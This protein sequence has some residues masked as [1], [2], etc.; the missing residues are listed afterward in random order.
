MKELPT[1]DEFFSPQDKPVD[2]PTADEFFA[3]PKPSTL[4][5]GTKAA[6]SIITGNGIENPAVNAFMDNTSAGRIMGAFGHAFAAGGEGG[7]LGIELGSDT[8]KLLTK[9]GV[10][11]DHEKNENEFTKSVNEAFIRPAAVVIDTEWRGFNAILGGIGSALQQSSEEIDK[12]LPEPVQGLLPE[13]TEYFLMHKAEMPHIPPEITRARSVGAIGES[14]ATYFGLKE[15][16]PEQVQGRAEANL[17]LSES[18]EV[19][20]IDLNKP[21]VS[22]AIEKD[23]HERAREISPEIFNEYDNLNTRRDVLG[24]WVRDLVDSRRKSAEETA[25]HNEEIEELQNKLQT[26]NARKSK[27]YQEKI[28]E[29]TEQNNQYIDEQVTKDTPDLKL[30]REQLQKVDYRMRDLAPDVSAAYREADSHVAKEGLVEEA[31]QPEKVN[32]KNE[33][34]ISNAINQDAPITVRIIGDNDRGWAIETGDSI[35]DITN[36]KKQGISNEEAIAIMMGDHATGTK[37]D[38]SKVKEKNATNIITD[39]VV[40]TSAAISPIEQQLQTIRDDVSKKLVKAGRP[41]EEAEGASQLIAEHYRAIAEQG[42]AKGTPEEIYIRDSANIKKGKETTRTLGKLHVPFQTNLKSTITLFSKADASTFLHETGHHWL[43]EMMNYAKA[44]DAPAGL[45]KDRD[46]VNNWLGVKEGEQIS[47]AQHEKFARGFERYLMEGTAPTQALANVFVK[48]KKWLTD[49]YQTVQKL[50]SPITDDIRHVFDRLLSANPERIVIAPELETIKESVPSVAEAPIISPEV[51]VN[52][53][54]IAQS[55]NLQP[56]NTSTETTGNTKEVIN[57]TTSIPEKNRNISESPNVLLGKPESKFVDR[58][59]NIRLDNLNTPED[60]NQVIRDAAKDNNDFY[61]ARRGVISDG[62]VLDLADALGMDPELLS[63]RK[64]GEAFNAEQIVSARRLLI[65]SAE[66]VRNLGAKASEGSEIDL[67]AYAEARGRHVMIQEQVS[68]ITAEAGRALRAFRALE[69]G[70]E[71]RALGD[72]IKESTNLDLFQ[73]QKEAALISELDTPAK[74]S[75]YINDLQKPKAVEYIQEYWI[76]ALLSNPVTHAKN[77]IGNAIITL[78][79]VIE[80]GIASKIGELRNAKEHIEIGEA[81]ARLYGIMQGATDGLI[82]AGKIMKDENA[83][84]GSHTVE[85]YRRKVI[86]GSLGK[87]IRLPTRFL[88]AEDEIFKAIGYRQELNALAYRTATKEGL[89]GDA[90]NQRM[91]SILQR[92]SE[93]MMKIAIDTA[94]YQTFTNPLG[95]IGRSIQNV[96]NSHPA[97][98]FVIPFVRTPTNILK[99]AGER[100]PFGLLSKEIRENLAGKNGEIARDIQTARLAWGS[101]IATAVAWQFLQGNVTSGGPTDPK[102][103]ALLRLTGWQPYSIKI[104]NGYYSYEWF[105][106][107]AT[108]IGTTADIADR[109]QSGIAKGDDIIKVASA[110]VT[111]ISKNLFSKLSLRGASD[112][113]QTISDPD[114]YGTRYLQNF[115]GSFVPAFMGQVARTADPILRETRTTLDSIESRIPG[116]KEGLFPK[117]DIWGN[118]IVSE[119]TL[120]PDMISPIRQTTFNNDPVNQRLLKLGYFPSKPDRKIMGVELTDQQYDDYCRLA[121]RFAKTRLNNYVAIPQTIVLPAEIQIETMRSIVDSSR[122][123]ARNIIKMN[124]LDI[125]K[126]AYQN[127]VNSAKKSISQ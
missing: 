92:P 118:P 66:N 10:F 33:Y 73:L 113:I 115:A 63:A 72:I 3:S 85:K 81:K 64:L 102:E 105:D 25:P 114:R 54:G 20:A 52:N 55:N 79:S 94:E 56:L 124:N 108:I 110:L 15:P 77:I 103:R 97:L 121:G 12:L 82:A 106:P 41:A 71:A 127:K 68:G 117:R 49:I 38:V 61:Q 109:I 80:T 24:K 112:L 39:E 44:E 11:N 13:L 91:A 107:L 47:R 28:D 53:E 48:F 70:A 29:L 120:G 116:L 98:K 122:E 14:E 42:W 93:D 76:N 21:E 18:S 99:Y 60:I 119:G 35:I 62:Q 58:A 6:S 4:E 57:K 43:N 32:D 96:A 5:L 51:S 23:V 90:F 111:S 9:Y 36:L 45:L 46:T 22:V 50:K 95:R 104:G 100:S 87:I 65:Q 7:S 59:G 75:Q 69:G 74:I 123:Q 16:T 2:L 1:P 83:I 101:T 26:A 67:L 88:S 17:I 31:G 34:E 78:N 126:Q 27:I 30:V 40:D 84:Q 125:I 8:E 89:T 37:P 19:K 86:P